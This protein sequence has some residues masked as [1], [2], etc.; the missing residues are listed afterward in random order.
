[1]LARAMGT[2]GCGRGVRT[3][4]NVGMWVGLWPAREMALLPPVLAY[5]IMGF[6]GNGSGGGGREIKKWAFSEQH[7]PSSLGFH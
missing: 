2:C 7:L 5:C 3:G 6:S 4:V 1:M